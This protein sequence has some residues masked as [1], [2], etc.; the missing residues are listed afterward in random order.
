[1]TS[2]KEHYD[3]EDNDDNETIHRINKKLKTCS[4]NYLEHKIQKV[5]ICI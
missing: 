4:Y 1:M 5:R 2:K 3:E